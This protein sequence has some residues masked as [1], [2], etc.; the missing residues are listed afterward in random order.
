VLEV[1]IVET[2]KH[3]GVKVIQSLDVG[4][5]IT[6]VEIVDAPNIYVIIKRILIGS[7]TKL[8]SGSGGVS[9]VRNL[10]RSLTLLTTTIRVVNTPQMVF[11]NLITITHVNR[12]INQPLMSSMVVG[13][14]KSAD[15]ASP[16]KG[17]RKPFVVTTPILDHIDG[18]YVKPNNVAL[19]YPNFK[20]DVNQDA[21]VKMFNSAIKTNVETSEEYFI[22]A[23]SNML[24]DTA[25]D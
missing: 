1:A 11:V 18:H 4:I 9:V 12:T 5:T 10:N 8:G 21:H 22:N 3:V 19:K 17:Y 13:R 16:K 2:R 20:K 6:R 15:A 7:A 25:S 24:K 23:F 14:Y